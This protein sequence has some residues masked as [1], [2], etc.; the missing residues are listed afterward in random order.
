MKGDEET[1]IDKVP[2]TAVL[3]AA[4]TEP[5]STQDTSAATEDTAIAH[6]AE[7]VQMRD[8]GEDSRTTESPPHGMPL[9]QCFPRNDQQ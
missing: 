9:A 3:A 2:D 7:L 8:E 4:P 6:S 5:E 1:P